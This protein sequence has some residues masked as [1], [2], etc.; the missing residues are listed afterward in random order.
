MFRCH[1]IVAR[2]IQYISHQFSLVNFP[3]LCNRPAQRDVSMSVLSFLAQLCHSILRT[4]S[5]C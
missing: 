1:K 3:P 4:A 2:V 5:A